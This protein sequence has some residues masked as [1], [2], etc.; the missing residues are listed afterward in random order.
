MGTINARVDGVD[1]TNAEL[2]RRLGAR[3]MSQAVDRSLIKGAEV[4]KSE[5]ETN[6]ESFK[7]T[8]ASKNEI[9]ISKPMTLAG[10]RT[11]VI[12]WSGPKNRYTI[13]HLNEFGT[14]KNPRPAG[15]GAIERA[16]RAGQAAYLRAVKEEIRRAI[17]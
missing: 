5:L 15:F 4:I 3:A 9:T 17:S 1:Q 2:E 16:L 8:G 7:D 13:I 14:V 6:F 10:K 12:Y 11:V